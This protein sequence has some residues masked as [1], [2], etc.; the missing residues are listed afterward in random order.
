MNE[1]KQ[2]WGS[3]FTK[4]GP[5]KQKKLS[6]TPPILKHGAPPRITNTIANT[7]VGLL[8]SII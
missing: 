6:S 8:R 1:K 7:A 5:Q 3:K 4:K 2:I